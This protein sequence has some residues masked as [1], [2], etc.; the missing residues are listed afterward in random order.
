MCF[1]AP[2][3]FVVGTILI[4]GGAYTLRASRPQMRR[5][6]AFPLL[7]GIQQLIEGSLW[8]SFNNDLSCMT[9]SLVFAYLILSHVFWPIYT[10]LALA[11]FEANALRKKFLILFSLLGASVGAFLFTTIIRET[12]AN[13]A[14]ACVKHHS[15]QYYITPAHPH[16]LIFLYFV[17]T[18]GSC[19]ISS[20]RRINYFGLALFLSLFAS[21]ELYYDSYLSVWCF[22]AAILSSGVYAIVKK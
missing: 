7:F 5:L 15:I 14:I 19:I 17:T 3:S 21:L 18:V 13:S 11:P 22:F 8:L 10:P 4:V 16:L 12:T 6:A 20:D 9:N 1:S 2:A